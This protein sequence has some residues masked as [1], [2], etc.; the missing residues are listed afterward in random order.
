MADDTVTPYVVIE[1]EGDPRP[2]QIFRVADGGRVFTMEKKDRKF[3]TQVLNRLN[4]VTSLSP[5]DT[6]DLANAA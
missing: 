6:D 5:E 3:A 2:W 1:E 4:G